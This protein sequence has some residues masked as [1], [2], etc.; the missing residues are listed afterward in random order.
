M[1]ITQQQ[2]ET[3]VQTIRAMIPDAR[4]TLFGSRTDDLKRGG[5]IDLYVETHTAPALKARLL[6]QYQLSCACDT[7]VDLLVNDHSTQQAI[8]NIAQQGIVL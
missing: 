6:L 4:V 8:F 5:D 2:R 1:R 7:K 3:I